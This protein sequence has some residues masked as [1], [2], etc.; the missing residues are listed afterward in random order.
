MIDFRAPPYRCVDGGAR[1]RRP[2]PPPGLSLVPRDGW[3]PLPR[4]RG[5]GG[6]RDI[7]ARRRAAVCVRGGP[8]PPP[9]LSLVPRDGWRPLPRLRGRGGGRSIPVLRLA[10]MRPRGPSPRQAFRSF[11][12]TAGDP[13][14][15]FGG[16]VVA[17]LSRCSDWPGCVRG[18]PPP[19][20]SPAN[21]A[22]EGERQRQAGTQSN[23]PPLPRQRGGRALAAADRCPS[24]LDPSV[25]PAS[26]RAVRG[27]AGSRAWRCGRRGR[28]GRAGAC[29]RWGSRARRPPAARRR[30]SR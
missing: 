10:W 27:R 4:L 14:P 30:P 26:R 1:A 20:P 28:G 16:G 15:N 17:A 9:G 19:R 6:S 7:A 13:S 12:A 24:S 18:G 2:S 8:S 5:R 11:L 29:G 22:G 3:R 25:M 21:C 23:S